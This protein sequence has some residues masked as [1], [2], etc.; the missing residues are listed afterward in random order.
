MI[1]EANKEKRLQWA[2]ENIDLLNK[3]DDVIYT[4]KTTVQMETHTRKC[5]YKRGR[6]LRYKPKPKHPLK[7]HVWGGISLRGRTSVCIFEGKMNA[8]L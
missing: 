5:C 2:K 6:K 8:P 1:R 3:F 7:L 4:D